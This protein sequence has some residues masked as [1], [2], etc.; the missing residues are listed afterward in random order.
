MM[1]IFSNIACCLNVSENSDDVAQYAKDLALQ[2]GAKLIVIYVGN[3]SG[4]DYKILD[5]SNLGYLIED[6]NKKKKEALEK[7]VKDN[8][9]G[10]DTTLVVTEGDPNKEMLEIIDKYCAD[11]AVVGSV[12]SKN[13]FGFITQM[14][15]RTLI[16]R[17]RIPVMI[18]PSEFSLECVP[19]EDE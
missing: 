15:S 7:Y 10:I 1:S 11:L 5:R 13:L 8:F 14:T 12:A 9:Q 4:S 6:N 17:T 18:I 16:E 3:Y 2:N 19:E